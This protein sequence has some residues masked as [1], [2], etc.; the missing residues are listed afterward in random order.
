MLIIKL[1]PLQKIVSVVG[2]IEKR[3]SAAK[4]EIISADL[5]PPEAYESQT[6]KATSCTT[7]SKQ[8]GH[9]STQPK[10]ASGVDA[11]SLS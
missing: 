11:F 5:T 3:T 4:V 10:T 9:R 7:H 1:G 6:S 8:K 2:L